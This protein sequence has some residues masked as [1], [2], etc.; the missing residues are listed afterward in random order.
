MHM[1]VDPILITKTVFK[2]TIA[3]FIFITAKN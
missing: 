1:S 2:L 3:I